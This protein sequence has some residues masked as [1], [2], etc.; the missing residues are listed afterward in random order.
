M[1]QLNEFMVNN[2]IWITIVCLFLIFTLIGY[3][4]DKSK[5]KNEDTKDQKK[6]KTSSVVKNEEVKE[7]INNGIETSNEKVENNDE[8]ISEPVE[9]GVSI[10]N[11]VNDAQTENSEVNI[12]NDVK[13]EETTQKSL[14]ELMAENDISETSIDLDETNSEVEKTKIEEENNEQVVAQNKVEDKDESVNEEI[15]QNVEIVNS[16]EPELTVENKDIVH[17]NDYEKKDSI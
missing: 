2:Y 1:E 11:E 16:W 8:K 17:E 12:D 15:P 4:A 5:N 10:E 14:E 7:I 9:V 3:M 6:E 13:T